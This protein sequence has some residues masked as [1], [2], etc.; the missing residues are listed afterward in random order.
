[1]VNK[2]EVTERLA[3]DLLGHKW[4]GNT[5]SKVE[6]DYVFNEP[7]RK[8]IR[9]I[10]HANRNVDSKKKY[11]SLC[12]EVVSDSLFENFD[13]KFDRVFY[14]T[15]IYLTYHEGRNKLDVILGLPYSMKDE[16][17]T[18]LFSEIGGC[19]MAVTEDEIS[20]KSYSCGV[21]A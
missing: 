13:I 21:K 2:F 3:V 11:L 12:N 19:E 7:V 4:V 15:C 20:Y 1:M 5:S 18:A 16:E 8:N 14:D 6:T 10:A 17:K 9:V